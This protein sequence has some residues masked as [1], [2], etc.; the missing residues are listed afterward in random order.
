[1]KTVYA[2]V[3][4]GPCAHRRDEVKKNEVKGSSAKEEKEG[5][6]K[7]KRK[8]K[9]G[10]TDSEGRE[11]GIPGDPSPF[12]DSGAK[13]QPSIGQFPPLRDPCYSLSLI[14]DFFFL[15]SEIK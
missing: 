13:C 8:K 7:E 12:S 2:G 5:K 3:A 15:K 6:R 1:M 10:K 14:P 11:R 9:K 4:D